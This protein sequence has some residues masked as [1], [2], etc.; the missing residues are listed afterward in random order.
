MLDGIRADTR[1]LTWQGMFSKEDDAEQKTPFLAT[2]SS[3]LGEGQTR[4]LR[5]DI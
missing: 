1:D 4:L 5:R 2:F 3:D